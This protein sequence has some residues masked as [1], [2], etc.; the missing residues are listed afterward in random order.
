MVYLA[1]KN[2]CMPFQPIKHTFKALLQGTMLVVIAGAPA[3]P[4]TGANVYLVRSQ[5]PASFNQSV[6]RI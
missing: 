2:L 4:N 3:Q 5:I 1:A 6:R